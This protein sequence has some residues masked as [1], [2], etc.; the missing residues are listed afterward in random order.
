MKGF[1]LI[2]L[3]VV[4]LIIGIL[5]SVALPQYTKAVE[6]SRQSEAWQTMKSINDA[7]KIA[8]MEKGVTDLTGIT[9]DDLSMTFIH[10]SGANAGASVTGAN[11]V[12]LNGKNFQY[13]LKKDGVVAT[14]QGGS[15]GTYRLG[16]TH[17]GDRGCLDGTSGTASTVCAK[18]GAKTTAAT[19]CVDSMSSCKA[20]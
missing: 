15:L 20:M 11:T 1:T 9:W 10:G 3:L 14:R 7:V 19:S 8:Q 18:V 13:T 4:V 6:K 17:S 12:T 2:E 16:L 5:S